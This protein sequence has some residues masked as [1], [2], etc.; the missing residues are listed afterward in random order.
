MK[1]L[2]TKPTRKLKMHSVK[3]ITEEEPSSPKMFL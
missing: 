3:K 1:N 2:K